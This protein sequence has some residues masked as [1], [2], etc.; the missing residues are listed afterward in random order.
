MWVLI[1]LLFEGIS[2]KLISIS[3]F[4]EKLIEEN[5]KILKM[6]KYPEENNRKTFLQHI[7]SFILVTNNLSE[8]YRT[9]EEVFTECKAMQMQCWV[10]YMLSDITYD[11]LQEFKSVYKWSDDLYKQFKLLLKNSEA[12]WMALLDWCYGYLEKDGILDFSSIP[13]HSS[14]E[15]SKS[16]TSK[17]K[18][19]SNSRSSNSISSS[20]ISSL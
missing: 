4:S 15:Q 6:Y 19:S 7:N 3:W 10:D 17:D 16:R 20:Q 2:C 12:A 11:K 9:G 5:T 13:K 18:S 14:D 8:R 1:I